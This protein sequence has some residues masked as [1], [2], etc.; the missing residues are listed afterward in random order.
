MKNPTKGNV[1]GFFLQLIATRIISFELVGNNG[2]QWVLTKQTTGAFLYEDAYS[3]L[4]IQFRSPWRGNAIIS[5]FARPN[6]FVDLLPPEQILKLIEEP[7]V[8]KIENRS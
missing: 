4:G 6:I 8:V 3:L 5:L 1:I 2:L 7:N